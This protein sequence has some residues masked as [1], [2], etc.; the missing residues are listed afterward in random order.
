MN[1]V[2]WILQGLLA[3]AYL[4]AGGIKLVT[5][6]DKLAPKMAWVENFTAGQVK[7]I[8][9]AELAGAFGLVLPVALNI[10]PILTPIAALGLVAVMAGAVSTHLRRKEPPVAPAVLAVLAVVVAL[11]RFLV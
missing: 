10:V 9:L 7:L 11:G 6:R 5:P 2:L 3:A 4:L 8:G 1:I